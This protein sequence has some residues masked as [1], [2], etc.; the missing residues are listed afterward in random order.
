MQQLMVMLKKHVE[1]VKSPFLPPASFSIMMNIQNTILP[2]STS[3]QRFHISR[4]DELAYLNSV[5]TSC[6]LLI[7]H[8]VICYEAWQAA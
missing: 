4:H 1:F 5:N 8:P 2:K 7:Q 6:M 3:L